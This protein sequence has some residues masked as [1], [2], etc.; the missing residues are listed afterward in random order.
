LGPEFL[1]MVGLA[2]ARQ[3]EDG[4]EPLGPE[5]LSAFDA[6]VKSFDRGFDIAAG[7]GDIRVAHPLLLVLQVSQESAT[8]QVTLPLGA[9]AHQKVTLKLQV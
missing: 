1:A 3:D 9:S 4:F 6:S 5:F 8:F 7:G 2:E